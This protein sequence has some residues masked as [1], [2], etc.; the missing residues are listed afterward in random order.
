MEEEG[1]GPGGPQQPLPEGEVGAGPGQ[2]RLGTEAAGQGMLPKRWGGGERER[3]GGGLEGGG[4]RRGRERK[5]ER[6]SSY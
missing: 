2:E 4:E 5:R 3:R 6:E 1:G